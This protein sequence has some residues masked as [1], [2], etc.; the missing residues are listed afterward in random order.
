MRV[1]SRTCTL[2]MFGRDV[3]LMTLCLRAR[4][5]A[6]CDA[7]TCKVSYALLAAFLA[8]IN[9]CMRARVCVSARDVAPKMV[10][11]RFT[12]RLTGTSGRCGIDRVRA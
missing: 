11:F 9:L 10:L 12:C 8:L 4:A 6:F 2:S 3:D 5:R 1:C 7:W